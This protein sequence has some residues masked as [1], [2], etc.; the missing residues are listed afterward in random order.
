MN[1]AAAIESAAVALSDAGITEA[2]REASSLLAYVLQK[3][4]VFLI[5][6]P[7]YELSADRS[8]LFKSVVRRRAKREPFQYITGRQ[9]F[10]GLDF[11]VATGVLI[12]RP[13]TEV[14]VQAAIEI[15]SHIDDPTFLE[16]GV[17]S[18]CISISILSAVGEAHALAVDISNDALA[19]AARNSARHGV[20]NRIVLKESDLFAEINGR[21][22]LIVSNPPYIN[23]RNLET[24]Q[25]EVRLFEPHSALSGGADGL[26]CIKRVSADAPKFLK[27]KGFILIEIGFDQADKVTDLFD[28]QLWNNVEFLRDLQDIKRVAKAQ[29]R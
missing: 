9:E 6:H 8:L 22:D 25:P 4:P 12:P 28:P 21:F 15:L 26:D 11:E 17:G 5:A 1:V 18:G 2:R 16:L 19:I 24:L 10:Y 20:G 13:E 7:E 23:E 27:P 3:E 29:I 14:L